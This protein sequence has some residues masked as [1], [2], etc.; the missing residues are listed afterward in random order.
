MTSRAGV[1]A[2]CGLRDLAA[3]TRMMDEGMERLP[4]YIS[5]SYELR[6]DDDL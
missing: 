5:T 3:G 2:P 6:A 4:Y 1:L